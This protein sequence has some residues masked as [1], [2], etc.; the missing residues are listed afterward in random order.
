MWLVRDDGVLNPAQLR[1]SPR[2][3]IVAR[4]VDSLQ[5]LGV[6]AAFVEQ[7]ASTYAMCSSTPGLPANYRGFL[8]PKPDPLAEHKARMAAMH[9]ETMRH[10][11]ITTALLLAAI[12]AAGWCIADVLGWLA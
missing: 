5:P 1:L 9:A 12:V 8:P 6:T 4:D 2:A 11:R 3:V 10:A 7:F